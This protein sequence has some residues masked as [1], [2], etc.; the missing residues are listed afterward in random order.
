MCKRRTRVIVVVLIILFA[1][2]ITSITIV[3]TKLNNHNIVGFISVIIYAYLTALAI[4]DAI[5]A[6]R[7]YDSKCQS[8]R[9]NIYLSG[10]HRCS[11]Y[12]ELAGIATVFCIVVTFWGNTFGTYEAI[13]GIYAIVLFALATLVTHLAANENLQIIEKLEMI[14]EKCKN[15]KSV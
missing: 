10:Y 12:S 2:V 4:I 9:K 15:S 13:E 14:E 7:P 1:I 5:H 8:I 11:C 3:A 6:T